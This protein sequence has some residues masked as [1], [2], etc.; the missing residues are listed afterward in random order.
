MTWQLPLRFAD[1]RGKLKIAPGFIHL[2]VFHSL[3]IEDKPSPEPVEGRG[4]YGFD[5]LSL[6]L[7]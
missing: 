2:G 7:V 6:R 5:K 4:G 1:V 3:K